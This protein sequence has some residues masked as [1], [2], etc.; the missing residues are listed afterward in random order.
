MNSRELDINNINI[1]KMPIYYHIHRGRDPIVFDKNHE[2]FMSKKNSFWYNIEKEMSN[3]EYLEYKI[4]IPQNRFTIS[5]N[6]RDKTKI[7]KLN[8]E[9]IKEYRKLYPNRDDER[10][11]FGGVDATNIRPYKLNYHDELVL[12]NWK[13]VKIELKCI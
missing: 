7:L 2:M 13:D 8:K 9:N 10:N 1:N 5:L 11:N 12:R 4:T 3:G 6:P